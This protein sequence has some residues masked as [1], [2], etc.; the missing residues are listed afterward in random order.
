[1]R[2]IERIWYQR[3]SPREIKGALRERPDLAAA[4]AQALEA[5]AKV[6]AVRAQS[7]PSISLNGSIGKLYFDN[8]PKTISTNSAIIGLS[9]PLFTGFSHQ[10][11]ILAAHAQQDAAY[12]NAQNV[13]DLVTLQVWTSYYNFETTDQ[14]VS[15]SNDLM[16]SATQNH[17]VA[18]GR[19]KAGVGS[20]LD[21]LTAQAA[22]ES[23]RAQQIQAR[24]SW[25]VALA[26]L[27]HDTGT[28]EASP[29]SGKGSLQK[30]DNK[31]EKK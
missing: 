3:N 7:Y 18:V 12:A 20:I 1:M 15:T 21:L 26:Q 8:S 11:D 6:R 29:P 9:V 4:R 19:Y 31:G 23:A 27:A 17:E 13:R 2:R 14:L 24:S 10:Y 25:W 5:A 22:L 16:E 30:T 28:L